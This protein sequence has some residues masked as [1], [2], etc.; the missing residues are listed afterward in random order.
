MVQTKHTGAR[1]RGPLHPQGTV[2]IGG[3]YMCIYPMDSPGGYQLVGRTLPI[4][5]AY[6]RTKAFTPDKP[7]LL[8]F[9]DQAGR[10]APDWDCIGC[11]WADSDL[12]AGGGAHAH[13]PL[14]WFHLRGETTARSLTVLS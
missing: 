5:N 1:D 10:G 8:E 3:S 2:G 11:A 13:T 14:T 12:S 7:W 6:G 4:W 9:F